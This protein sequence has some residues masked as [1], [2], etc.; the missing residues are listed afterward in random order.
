M[1]DYKDIEALLERFYDGR[2]SE[3][4]EQT[5]KDF[6][7]QEEVPPHLLTEN[8]LFLQLSAHERTERLGSLVD[9]WEAAEKRSKSMFRIRWISGIAAS[10]LLLIGTTWHLQEA[11]TSRKDTCATPEEAYVETQ[12]ALLRFSIALNKGANELE[13]LQ[14]TTEKI[15][16]FIQ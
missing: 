6:F 12:K 16:K 11:D 5:L 14:K 1:K 13:S 8:E 7:A 15:G 4:E 9:Q 10:L 3:S 2:T